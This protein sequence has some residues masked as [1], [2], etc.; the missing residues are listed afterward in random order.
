MR[1]S[2]G[3]IFL[4]C[5]FYSAYRVCKRLVW[6]G[7]H[8]AD[9]VLE[10]PWCDSALIVIAK[11][12]F[13]NAIDVAEESSCFEEALDITKRVLRTGRAVFNG[14]FTSSI[15][16]AKADIIVPLNDDFKELLVICPTRGVH[17][18]FIE[19]IAHTAAV[20]LK[21]GI[22]LRRISLLKPN[23]DY[24]KTD[25]FD[26]QRY[27][28]KQVITGRIAARIHEVEDNVSDIFKVIRLP[29][30]PEQVYDKHC[31][32]PQVCMFFENC[33]GILPDFNIL[34]LYRG[35]KKAKKLM[36]AGILDLSQIS[37]DVELTEKQQIQVIA[38]KTGEPFVN[39]R[40]I[41][42]FLKKLKYPLHF[43]DFETIAPP[44]PLF[45]NTKPFEMVPYEFSLNI[46]DESFADVKT[47]NYIAENVE[48]PRP[49][50]LK[51]LSVQIK[52]EGSIVAYNA[53]FEIACLRDCVRA[54]P[55]FTEW[56]EGIRERMVDLLKPF[57]SLDYYHPEQRG[58]ASL[59]AVLPCLTGVSY[60][61]LAIKNGDQA[62][63]CFLK[64]MG[65]D[66]SAEEKV[67]I[68]RQLEEYCFTDSIGMLWII[69]ALKKLVN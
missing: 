38:T 11:K 39:K 67:A 28:I 15:G 48:D 31:Y 7:W 61:R 33:W 44:V 9:G 22:E 24:R 42:Q 3:T 5:E 59:K 66:V 62:A 45:K 8:T 52:S 50:I 27:F 14:C 36:E 56:F 25:M 60:S 47:I 26:P 10:N 20:L 16:A 6:L 2:A 34:S 19:K 54:Y 23:P 46:Q 57:K 13:P 18:L 12:L 49:E 65:D 55:E 29:H 68:K 4:D 1:D 41:K 51:I 21:N 69:E 64:M 58:S 53:G 40:A 37:N 32:N 35:G 43:L 30:P 63:E 17:P